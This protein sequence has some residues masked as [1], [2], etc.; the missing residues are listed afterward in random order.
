LARNQLED[1]VEASLR[2]IQLAPFKSAARNNLGVALNRLGKF[3]E[4]LIQLRVAASHDPMNTGA[5]L[6]QSSPLTSLRRP[7]EA[8]QVLQQ[9]TRVAPNKASIWANLGAVQMEVE[10]EEEAERSLRKALD[11]HPG[12]HEAQENLRTLITRRTRAQSERKRPNAAKLIAE[13]RFEEA[14]TVLLKQVA[15][16]SNNVD[17]WHNLGIIALHQH[18]ER[19]A[20][21]HFKRVVA[22]KPD[23]EFARKQLIRLKGGA[24]D[25]A[26]A[27]RECAELAKIPKERMYAALW[28]AQLLQSIGETSQ[29]ILELQQLVHAN[30]ELDQV[31]FILSEIYERE[32]MLEESLEAAMKNL[33]ILKKFGGLA[34]NIKIT[35]ERIARLRAARR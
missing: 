11:L 17:A 29:A 35:E 20:I 9:A 24:G 27:L 12:L 15:E 5:L 4:A 22:I 30:H 13:G 7:L 14:E 33:A 6:N 31:W 26:G 18:H 32:G 8:I 1:S 28:R 21:E 3:D 19:K 23:E 16:N 2:A 25:I 10:L 34:D